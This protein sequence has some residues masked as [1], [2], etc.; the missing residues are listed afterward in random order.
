[1][2]KTDHNIIIW[3]KYLSAYIIHETS[4]LND[5][6]EKTTFNIVQE[7]V[8]DDIIKETAFNDTYLM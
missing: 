7:T 1:M 3:L 2:K 5:I 4:V 6:I 8:F